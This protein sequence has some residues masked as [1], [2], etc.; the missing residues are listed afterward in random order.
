MLNFVS[1]IYQFFYCPNVDLHPRTRQL[2]ENM[3]PNIAWENIQ[4]YN[5]LPWY[6]RYAR[7]NAIVIPSFY[8][9]NVH[10][11]LNEYIG[12]KEKDWNLIM[13]HESMHLLQHQY[14]NGAFPIQLGF[15]HRF[16]RR[17]LAFWLEIPKKNLI[18]KNST[19]TDHPFEKQAFYQENDF[20][21]VEAH[22]KAHEIPLFLKYFPY[23]V[24]THYYIQEPHWLAKLI[25][26]P[27]CTLIQLLLFVLDIPSRGLRWVL[28]RW[29]KRFDRLPPA[30]IHYK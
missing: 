23:L 14:Y 27:L 19:Y 11:Y 29:L 9:N 2:I 10:I 20:E 15:Y 25:A 30:K 13:V 5:R 17:Y 16:I 24:K 21:Q 22:F 4:F 8:N 26:W 18:A 7:I 3:Y 1:I 12:S 28:G 6:L